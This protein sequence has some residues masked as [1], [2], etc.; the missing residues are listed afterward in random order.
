MELTV[1][2]YVVVVPLSQDAGHKTQGKVCSKRG[3]DTR[4]QKALSEITRG[5][6][7][8]VSTKLSRI[9]FCPR[10]NLQGRILLGISIRLEGCTPVNKTTTENVWPRINGLIKTARS[11][12]SKNR[13]KRGFFCCVSREILKT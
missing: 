8:Q 5:M 11:A 4:K 1:I 3:V 2:E 9:S 12:V 10:H 7:L 6:A 13:T